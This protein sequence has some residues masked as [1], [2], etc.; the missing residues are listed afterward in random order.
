[1]THLMPLTAFLLLTTAPLACP[2]SQSTREPLFL[3]FSLT[4]NRLSAG[5]PIVLTYK[6]T[7]VSSTPVGVYLTDERAGWA[8][9]KDRVGWL[10]V[11]ILGAKGQGVPTSGRSAATQIDHASMPGYQ[12]LGP[13]STIHGQR[14][15]SRYLM[16]SDPGTYRLVPRGTI[17]YCQGETINDSQRL[18]SGPRATDPVYKW[19]VS[20]P[21]TVTI[22]NTARLRR[23]ADDLRAQAISAK[24][25]DARRTALLALFSMPEEVV[26]D[27]WAELGKDAAFKDRETLLKQL[28]EIG[29]QSTIGLYRELK[30][31]WA[32]EAQKP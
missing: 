20:L 25:V 32:A 18:L 4:S 3:E 14:L 2:L 29:T 11:D 23:V 30:A 28:R 8:N 12:V 19:E 15:L 10:S 16:T 1:M 21:L 9:D 22:R 24:G 5:E 7:N 26:L 6:L 31:K 27:I 13:G 17:S